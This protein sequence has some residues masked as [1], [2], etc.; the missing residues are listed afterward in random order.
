MSISGRPGIGSYV[1]GDTS[2]SELIEQWIGEQLQRGDVARRDRPRIGL[3]ASSSMLRDGGWPVYGGDAPTAQAILRAGG[4]PILIP[5]L[6]LLEGYDPLQ[7]FQDEH[8]FTLFFEL[9]WPVVRDLDGIVFSGGGDLS[10]CLYHQQPHPQSE[11][12]DLWRDVWERYHLGGSPA[13]ATS[14]RRVRCRC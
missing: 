11:T 10:A 4:F 12:P 8:T 6:P 7:V 1:V 3:V 2:V 9:L 14:R 5:L 13:R